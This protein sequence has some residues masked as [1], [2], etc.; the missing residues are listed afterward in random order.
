MCGND[1]TVLPATLQI[2][3]PSCNMWASLL[4]LKEYYDTFWLGEAIPV[5]A[6]P[7][8]NMNTKLNHSEFI[9]YEHINCPDCRQ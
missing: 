8:R 7:D 9:D 3:D 5:L 1:Q 6:W 4:G 2:P